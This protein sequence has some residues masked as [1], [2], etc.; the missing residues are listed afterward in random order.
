MRENKFKVKVFSNYQA[1]IHSAVAYFIDLAETSIQERGAFFVAL[2]GGSTP[3]PLYRSLAALHNQARI[4]WDRVHLFWGDERNV[5][6]DHPD[7]NFRMVND[8]LIDHVQI[9]RKNIHRV[10]TEMDLWQAAEHYEREMHR[11][12]E[13]EMP[14]FDLLLLGM[15]ED[16]HTASLFPHSAGL[17]EERRW[18]IANFAPEKETWRFTLTKNAINSARNIIVLVR[19]HT[20]AVKLADVFIG[21]PDPY[22]KPIQLIEPINGQIIWMVE[23]ASAKHL[24]S[25]F[26]LE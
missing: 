9:P 15:G 17:F 20:K 24:P 16:G 12:F 21:S 7:S 22:S 19:G 11:V 13:E 18:F 5:P 14:N 3:Q 6:A 26:Q 10:P 4:A 1:L 23:K 8:A 2:S 25:N